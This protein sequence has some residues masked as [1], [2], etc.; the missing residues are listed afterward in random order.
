MLPI[1]Y[2]IYN[3]M[4]ASAD[5][6][7]RVEFLTP[8]IQRGHL[9]TMRHSFAELY[10]HGVTDLVARDSD[11]SYRL[12]VNI[13][14]R[15]GTCWYGGSQ[16]PLHPSRWSPDAP[17]GVKRE[18][19]RA[20]AN[21]SLI[22]EPGSFAEIHSFEI[23]DILGSDPERATVLKSI[24]KGTR[25]VYSGAEHPRNPA[26]AWHRDFAPRPSWPAAFKIEYGSGVRC[27]VVKHMRRSNADETALRE[28]AK[29]FA[30]NPSRSERIRIAT[31]L[32]AKGGAGDRPRFVAVH[33]GGGRPQT[34][35]LSPE[36]C[37]DLQLGDP[38]AEEA[39]LIKASGYDE[40]YT[41]YFAA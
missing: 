20:V 12:I 23:G 35:L 33:E 10:P 9:L 2:G 4:S 41:R 40:I 22:L 19:D 26:S 34:L 30:A 15:G 36:I 16:H 11:D 39:V 3:P 25:T 21:G 6:N 29:W 14:S 8:H 31:A 7:L 28:D 13:L 5:Y 1:S 38:A 17:S 24:R 37:E 27:G 18:V 32:E